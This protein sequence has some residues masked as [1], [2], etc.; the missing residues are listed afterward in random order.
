MAYPQGG[1][2]VADDPFGASGERPYVIIS[3]ARHPFHG[4]EYI[5]LVITSTERDRAIPLDEA[6]YE[7]G[8]LPQQSYISPWN[9]MTLKDWMIIKHVATL[10]DTVVNDA[11]ARLNTYIGTP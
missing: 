2:V 3:D 5:A 11:V 8:S 1:V 4:T 9:P 7:E 6:A 10:T